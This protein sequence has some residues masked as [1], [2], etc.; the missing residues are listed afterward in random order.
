MITTMTRVSAWARC[1][2][3]ALAL[4]A[5]SAAVAASSDGAGTVSG[6]VRN[7]DG[8]PV[9][10]VS[11]TLI[12]DQDPPITAQAISSAQGE[13]RFTGLQSGN[14]HVTATLPGFVANVPD[15]VRLPSPSATSFAS[16]KIDFT[17]TPQLSEAESK[18]AAPSRLPPKF[19]AAGVRGLIDSG[20]YSA[21]ANAAAASV[22]IG[23]VA[24][25]K[26]S[27]NTS[28]RSAAQDWP[29]DLE[30]ELMKAVAANPDKSEPRRR[31]A[32]FY[33]AHDQATNAITLLEEARGIKSARNDGTND[34]VSLDFA[35]AWMKTGRFDAAR[36]VLTELAARHDDR[37]I[38]ES[39]IHE[40]G[41]H[42]AEI[43]TLLARADE[44]SG[45]FTQASRE[46]QIAATAEPSEDNLF[47]TGYELILAG[48][49][50]DAAT[51]FLSGVQKYPHSITLLIG[52]GTAEFLEG[53]TS[54]SVATFLQA[55]D[56]DPSDPRPYA[57][58]S[59]AFGRSGVESEKVRA[60]FKRFLDLAPENARANYFY[61]LTLLAGRGSD[62]GSKKDDN[63]KKNDGSALDIDR[64]EGLFKR[65]I[66]LDPN[67][68]KAHFQLGVLYADR[69]EYDRA[70]HEYEASVR[71]AP[72]FNEAHYR[73]AR[74][75]RRAGSME[76]AAH[77]MQ[78]FQ[79][80]RERQASE[81]GT[82]ENIEQFI[83]VMN[84]P[85]PQPAAGEQC[86][87]RTK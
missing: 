61:A 84:R 30:P 87:D 54:D 76:L 49:A 21:P 73:L 9:G 7:A 62:K 35:V 78:L 2:T 58:L 56:T 8:K 83:S 63:D 57:L 19:E 51:A 12:S 41:I 53:Q 46:Y 48:R 26:R 6:V 42:E 25:I 15:I 37:D 80:A 72:D 64:V 71:L 17:L 59:S 45:L 16:A 33:L 18:S 14:Y 55:T 20:G 82:A 65:A 43:H 52:V 85:G 3:A 27:G 31:L 81:T 34:M 32:E 70:V 67:F 13:Y 4:V 44:G 74:A 86:R 36:D 38:H 66:L 5:G 47:G 10:G 40:T 75:Y 79:N 28:G 50:A 39:E 1:L 24:D 77:E 29:C 68:A 60:S 69:G 22:L 11:V 23:G